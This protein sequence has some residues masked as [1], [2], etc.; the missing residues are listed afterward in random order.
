MLTEAAKRPQIE[1]SKC[2]ERADSWHAVGSNE[3]LE[4]PGSRGE[5]NYIYRCK[6]CKSVNTLS[7]CQESVNTLSE[8]QLRL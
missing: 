3:L 6:L 7:E 2:H 4:I 5:A 8:C 1:C